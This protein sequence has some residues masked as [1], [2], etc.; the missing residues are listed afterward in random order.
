LLKKFSNFS[1]D[2]F[3]TFYWKKII[4]SSKTSSDRLKLI[5]KTKKK[6]EKNYVQSRTTVQGDVRN[7]QGDVRSGY[8]RVTLGTARVMLGTARVTLGTARVTLGPA[9]VTLGMASAV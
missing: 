4:I 1:M 8:F 5:Y 2:Q 9:S 3:S 7:G 6:E